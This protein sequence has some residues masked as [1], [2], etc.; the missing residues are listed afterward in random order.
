MATAIEAG[1]R[2]AQAADA[3]PIAKL[4]ADSWR[5]HYRGTYS[6]SY[7]DGDLDAD[8]LAVWIKRLSHSARDR[9]TLVAE[10]QARLIGFAHV[11]LDTDSTWGALVENLHVSRSCQRSGVAATSWMPQHGWCSNG[12]QVLAST[13]GSSNKTSQPKPF[14]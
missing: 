10:H 13:C 12:A 1:I 3:P 8:R 4:H 9:F 5:R 14:T 7:L 6:D 2:L 11:V